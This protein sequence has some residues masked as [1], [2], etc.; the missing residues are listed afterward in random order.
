MVSE[1]NIDRLHGLDFV[2]GLCAVAVM[3]Y[4]YL[5]VS[6]I[7][8]FYAAGT[9]GVYIFF[10]LSGFTLHQV[11]GS[12]EINETNLRRFFLNRA[13]RIMPL[14]IAVVGVQ[15]LFASWGRVNV[16]EF[17]L[18]VTLLFGLTNPGQTSGTPGGWSIGVE[19][20]F[21]LLFPMLLL[22]RNTLSLGLVFICTLAINHLYT[23]MTYTMPAMEKAHWTF[24][25]Q[26]TTF[27]CFFVGGMFLAKFGVPKMRTNQWMGAAIIVAT[28]VAM[29]TLPHL[30]GVSRKEILAGW[31]AKLMIAASLAVVVLG[32][33]VDLNGFL[34][35]LARFLGE[36]SYALY[37]IHLLVYGQVVRWL[38][39]IG[40]LPTIAVSAALSVSLSKIIYDLFEN[41]IRGWGKRWA[42]RRGPPAGTSIQRPLGTITPYG[43]G[44]TIP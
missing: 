14:Y 6:K 40:T 34:E 22:F 10:V 33:A 16:A 29:F 3:I 25:I 9:Y 5:H 21:Y 15:F 35:R 37:L 24:H 8:T 27:L 13:F 44:H 41:P 23:G 19:A 38:P 28:M 43:D 2:R 32:A 39:E 17:A 4:H 26:P 11:Y 12:Q 42:A 20:V 18:N 1:A 36:I 31:E 7:G 30:L